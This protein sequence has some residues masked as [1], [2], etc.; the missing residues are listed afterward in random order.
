MWELVHSL[1]A[2]R[3]QSLGDIAD[4]LA[5]LRA[6]PVARIRA[7]MTLFATQHKRGAQIAE[8]YLTNP[9]RE[10]R[11][12]A[13]LLETYWARAIDPVWPRVRA[14]LDADIAYRAR[15]LTAGGPAT[16]FT[17]LSRSVSW[18]QSDLEVDI[19]VHNATVNLNGRGLLFFF[20]FFFFF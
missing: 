9:R 13:D 6:T 11:R 19:P 20:F 8:P 2:L 1:L 5:A 16:L 10:V 12:L 18:E 14:F 4:D 7:D 15:R 17:D 3:D